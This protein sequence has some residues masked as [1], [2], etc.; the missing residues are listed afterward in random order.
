MEKTGPVIAQFLIDLGQQ[1][2]SGTLGLSLPWEQEV[3]ARKLG[4]Y[5][6][7]ALLFPNNA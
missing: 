2:H 6:L 4:V 7:L 3:L 5:S 1:R